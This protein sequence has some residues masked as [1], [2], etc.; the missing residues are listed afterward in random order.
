MGAGPRRLSLIRCEGQGSSR[1]F[2][3][4][5]LSGCRLPDFGFSGLDGRR[6]RLSDFSGHYVLLDFWATW[7]SICLE[8]EPTLRKAYERFRGRGL[9]IVGLDSDK[10]PAKALKYLTEHQLPWPQSATASTKNV[11]D[12]VLKVEW[13]PTMVLLNPEGKILFVTGNGRSFLRGKKLLETLDKLLP[14]DSSFKSKRPA[15]GERARRY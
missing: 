15:A 10:H 11:L 4:G 12:H 14:R 3:G 8:E 13:Y 2:G 7:C 1:F 9:E 5:F 6:Y